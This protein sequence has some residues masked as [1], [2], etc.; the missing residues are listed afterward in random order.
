MDNLILDNFNGTSEDLASQSAVEIIDFLMLKHHEYLKVEL[1]RVVKLSYT[2]RRVHG[3]THPE[4]HEIEKTFKVIAE[5][6]EDYIQVEESRFFPNI[7]ESKRLNLGDSLEVM[8]VVAN[9]LKNSQI[10]IKEG[11]EKLKGQTS[12]NV[13]PDDGCETFDLTYKL[14]SDIEAVVNNMFHIENRYLFPKII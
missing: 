6:I 10:N 3:E 2:I 12:N 8:E 5:Q 7:K 1:P 9:D 11:F 4:L 14:Y 13:A